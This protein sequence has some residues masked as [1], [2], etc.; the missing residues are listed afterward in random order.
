MNQAD[1]AFLLGVV[2]R[3]MQANPKVVLPLRGN[4]NVYRLIAQRQIFPKGGVKGARAY[5][6]VQRTPENAPRPL[7]IARTF[8]LMI[9]K[10]N[11][12]SS[13]VTQYVVS[14]YSP[15]TIYML[16]S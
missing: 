2:Q 12:V 3:L 16:L 9:I 15:R 14:T 10:F 7:D 8:C 5:P 6:K 11:Q 4:V 1:I 13:P